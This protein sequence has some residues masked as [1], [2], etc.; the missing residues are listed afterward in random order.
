MTLHSSCN[1]YIIHSDSHSNSDSNS[2]SHSNNYKWTKHALER[3]RERDITIDPSH[4]N[5]NHVI[6]LP[7]T[8]EN[9]CYKYCDSKNG[10]TYY[11]RDNEIVTVIKINPIS[12]RRHPQ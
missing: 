4:V 9:G 1:K 12:S 6:K 10:I 7:Y 5:I 2:D 11:I 3:R 8:I